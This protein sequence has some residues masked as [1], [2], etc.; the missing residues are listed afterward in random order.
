MTEAGADSRAN[1]LLKWEAI[2]ELAGAG[3]DDAT[4]CGA[5]PTPGSRTS[6]PASAA[7]R[8]RYIGAWDL[9]LDALGRRT[10]AVA[11][12]ARVRVARLRHGLRGGGSASAP[13]DRRGDGPAT[14]GRRRGDG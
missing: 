2:R 5:S 10:Y 1:Y 12:R 14:A 8:S 4:T 6:R 13:G 11:Q 3:R 9:V 7:A